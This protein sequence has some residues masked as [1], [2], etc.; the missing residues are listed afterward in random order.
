M[1]LKNITLLYYLL[2][3]LLVQAQHSGDSINYSV[4]AN[5]NVGWGT[6]APFLSTANRYDM[7]SFEPSALNLIGNIHKEFRND[8]LFDYGFGLSTIANISKDE[9]RF[10]LGEYYFESKISF[11]H[12]YAG[13]KREVFGN[14]D[15][16]LSSGGMLWSKNSRPLPKISIQSNGYLD[17]PF[18]KSYIAVK[19][20]ISHGWFNDNIVMKNLLLHHKYAGIKVGGSSILNLNYEFQ[21]VAQ[22]GGISSRNDSMPV[23]F[24]NYMRIF[25]GKSG[26]STASMS[27]Q[28][29]TLGNHIISQNLGLDLKLNAIDIS[30]YWQ[31][32]TEDPPVYPVLMYKAYNVEDGLWGISVKLKKCKALNSFVLE[33]MQTTDRS[34]PWHDFDGVIYGGE[35]DYYRNGDMIWAYRSMTIG[36]PWLTSP[37]YNSIDVSSN[38]TPT[39]ILNNTLRLYY[40]SGKGQIHPF[41][42]RLTLAYSEN[43]GTKIANYNNCKKQFSYQLETSLA[44]KFIQNTHASFSISGDKGTQ[45]GDNF[46]IMVGLKYANL[47]SIRK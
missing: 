4:D 8:R 39:T 18:T 46:A 28:I 23:T 15:A 41:N 19:G 24:D 29:N 16:E 21:H 43:F 7:Y 22:W 6:N 44:L 2:L 47:F 10:F 45:Y 9:N 38:K 25:K 20:G 14:Q 42:Y 32:I 11:L 1:K 37:K 34:G 30:L 13:S 33:Y 5:A 26:S 17:V 40:F 27:D 35:D 12:I 31:N 36:N 3:S